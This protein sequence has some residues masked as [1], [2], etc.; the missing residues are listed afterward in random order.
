MEFSHSTSVAKIDA[1]H[2]TAISEYL[3]TQNEPKE[4]SQSAHKKSLE[5]GRAKHKTININGN[6]IMGMMI[7]FH[8]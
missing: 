6:I 5:T 3:I 1:R 4:T 2:S 8:K 7:V